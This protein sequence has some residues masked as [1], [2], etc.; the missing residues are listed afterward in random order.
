MLVLELK[1][2]WLYLEWNMAATVILANKCQRKW[3]HDHRKQVVDLRNPLGLYFHKRLWIRS[4]AELQNVKT[5]PKA[6]PLSKWILEYWYFSK[7][8]QVICNASIVLSI[9]CFSP[10]CA[11]ACE[12]LLEPNAQSLCYKLLRIFNGGSR[13]LNQAQS[14]S[15]VPSAH[16][17]EVSPAP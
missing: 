6:G 15:A 13:A 2:A 4:P 12:A 5:P 8:S 11:I 1:Q 17:H 7:A 9:I 3:I 14:L 10:G 16:A